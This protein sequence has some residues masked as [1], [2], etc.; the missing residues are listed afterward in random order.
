MRSRW[1]ARTS[2][3]SAL[4]SWFCLRRR[5]A[6]AA[7]IGAEAIGAR[8][9][10]SRLGV[11]RP[12]GAVVFLAQAESSADETAS[13]DSSVVAFLRPNRLT[14]SGYFGTTLGPACAYRCNRLI[15]HE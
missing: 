4:V 5:L 8:R 7:V 12:F 15:V 1:A 13:A 10:A 6:S 14:S 3:R 9:L 2:R 11:G